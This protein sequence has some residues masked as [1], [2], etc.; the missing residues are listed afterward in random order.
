M[1]PT[2]RGTQGLSAGSAHLMSQLD[3]SK[4]AKAAEEAIPGEW[5]WLDGCG[6]WSDSRTLSQM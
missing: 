2:S 6:C 5:V 4:P 1:A 3:A